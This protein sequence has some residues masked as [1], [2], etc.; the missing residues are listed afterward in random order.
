MTPWQWWYEFWLG[1]LAA[2]LPPAKPKL[3]LVPKRG[4]KWT[5]LQS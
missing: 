5:Y 2:I 1:Y 3:Y 4:L